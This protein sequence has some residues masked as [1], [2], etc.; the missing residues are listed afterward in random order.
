MDYQAM[1]AA[2]AATLHD[3]A[4]QY[5]AHKRERKERL[6]E[7]DGFQVLRENN[8]SMEV[9]GGG[10]GTYSGCCTYSGWAVLSC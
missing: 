6:I 5:W 9:S 8:Y 3:I 10:R 1:R 4:A 2:Q 7:I